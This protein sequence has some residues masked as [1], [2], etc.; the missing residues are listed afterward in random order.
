MR[1]SVLAAALLLACSPIKAQPV[2]NPSPPSVTI[3][4]RV[5]F[6]HTNLMVRYSNGDRCYYVYNY[7]N[8]VAMDCKF[9]D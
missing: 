4:E 2:E 6:S 9:N 1:L 3:V 8:G 5:E 7:S